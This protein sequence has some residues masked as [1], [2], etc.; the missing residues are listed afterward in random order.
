MAQEKWPGLSAQPQQLY[1]LPDVRDM[2]GGLGP[3]GTLSLHQLAQ[4]QA[5]QKLER[6]F[7]WGYKEKTMWGYKEK[8]RS[9]KAVDNLLEE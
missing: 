1:Q 6:A 2:Q 4:Q 9:R 7:W 8:T 3:Q 5:I